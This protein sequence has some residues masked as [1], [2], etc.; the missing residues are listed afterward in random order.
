MTFT[1]VNENITFESFDQN[2]YS[3]KLKL[4]TL[5]FFLE[6]WILKLQ[7]VFENC[8]FVFWVLATNCEF[9]KW[10][11]SSL[12]VELQPYG[13]KKLDGYRRAVVPPIHKT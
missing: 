12:A 10:E 2:N 9:S 5:I 1:P 11:V 3:C 7:V 13:R 8:Q 6:A 4:Q